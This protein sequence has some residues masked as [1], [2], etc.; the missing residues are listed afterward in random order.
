MHCPFVFLF[1]HFSI[2]CCNQRRNEFFL[3][4]KRTIFLEL[5]LIGIFRSVS[6]GI[7]WYLPYQYQRK[8]RSVHFGII[9]L[10]GTPFSLKKGALA[11]FLR[12][13]GGTG[14]LSDTASPPF[15]D[16][17]SSRRTS[18][19]DRNTDRPVKSDTGKIPIPK[20]LLVTPWYRLVWAEPKTIATSDILYLQQIII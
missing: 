18:T 5:Y 7:S 13:K 1:A 15:A 16:K 6:V 12:E 17:R 19:T 10:A 11:P 14:P 20:K 4:G 2:R 9:Y 8:S 3:P